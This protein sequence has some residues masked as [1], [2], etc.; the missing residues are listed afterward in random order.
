MLHLLGWGGAVPGDAFGSRA[1]PDARR[2]VLFVV[3]GLGHADL[4]ARAGVAP[5]LNTHLLARLDSVAP[6]TTAA[7]LTAL[8]TGSAPGVHGIVGQRV[9]VPDGSGH[10][11]EYDVLRSLWS[12]QG[13]GAPPAF[14]SGGGAPPAFEPPTPFGGARPYVISKRKHL[15]TGFTALHL[16]SDPEA[17]WKTPSAMV[18]EVARALRETSG[19]IY[20]YYDGLDTTAHHHGFGDHYDAELGYVDTVVAALIDLLPASARLVVTSDHGCVPVAAYLAVPRPVADLCAAIGGEDRNAYLISRPGREGELASAAKEHFQDK[21][22]VMTRQEALHAGIY[23][24]RVTPAARS[25]I[26]DV[27]I[28]PFPG[29]GIRTSPGEGHRPASPVCSHGSLS[30]AEL[31]VP[32]VVA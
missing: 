18:V 17:V 13:G 16:G 5:S 32:V 26:G 14:E 29:Y 10:W 23:G 25:R 28:F 24:P 4:V 1:R 2:T 30:A 19:D 11:A 7:A 27:R 31:G 8:T 3:D 21:A 6:T 22:W 9:P 15:G 20:L 12:R